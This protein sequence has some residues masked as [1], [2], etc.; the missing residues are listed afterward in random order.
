MEIG[1][2]VSLLDANE[3][4]NSSLPPTPTFK[5]ETEPGQTLHWQEWKSRLDSLKSSQ[6]VI[7]VDPEGSPSLQKNLSKPPRTIVVA[8]ATKADDT[9]VTSA[10]KMN[11]QEPVDKPTSQAQIT[12]SRTASQSGFFGRRRPSENNVATLSAMQDLQ[13]QKIKYQEENQD[14]KE[15]VDHL[16]EMLAAK[17]ERCLDLERANT[18][19]MQELEDLTKSL[20]EEANKMVSQAN[21]SAFEKDAENKLLLTKLSQ[22]ALTLSILENELEYERTKKYQQSLDYLTGSFME[23]RS[24]PKATTPSLKLDLRPVSVMDRWPQVCSDL[25]LKE[26]DDFIRP[27]QANHSRKLDEHPFMKRIIKEDIEPSIEAIGRS[28]FRKDVLHSMKSR[29]LELKLTRGSDTP[30]SVD[31]FQMGSLPSTPKTPGGGEDVG[32][33]SSLLAKSFNFVMQKEAAD[34]MCALCQHAPNPSC[35]MRL[36]TG[37]RWLVL[38]RYCYEKLSSAYRLYLL[39]MQIFEGDDRPIMEIFQ[40][41]T[42]E[43]LR[44]F[45]ARIMPPQQED[46][47]MGLHRT[48]HN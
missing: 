6:A 19:L 5:E 37:D 22:Q 8:S 45:F 14:L 32:G 46:D 34:P 33:K 16:R 23:T 15:T 20:F 9:I 35:R 39:C 13:I 4:E 18:G 36:S 41:V 24:L 29:S 43:R 12:P 38:D 7:I 1:S 47:R 17:T 21:R 25:L 3:K 30:V 44:V 48:N 11:D 10:D 27:H 26:F 42:Q 31:G 40:Q 28:G 2:V